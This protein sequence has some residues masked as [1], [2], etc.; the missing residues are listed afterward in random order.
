VLGSVTWM[1]APQLF[2]E[3]P[4]SIHG[5]IMGRAIVRDPKVFL[6]SLGEVPAVSV[7]GAWPH[8]TAG[9]GSLRRTLPPIDP[10]KQTFAPA[11]E[12]R[13]NRGSVQFSFTASQFLGAFVTRQE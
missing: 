6:S 12:D 8:P 4:G 5:P 2:L 1:A 7:I 11:A 9:F 10:A 3:L 13:E